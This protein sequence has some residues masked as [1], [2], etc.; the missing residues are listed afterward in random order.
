MLRCCIIKFEGSWEK[1]LPLAEFAYNNS[2]HT[3]IKMAPFEALY[4]RKCRNPL[5][6]S[7]LSE[8]KITGVDLVCEAEEK[9]KIIQGNL[10]A[11]FDR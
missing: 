1:Y 3:S 5:C 6:W 7:K 8:Q 2:Y 10:K 4:E 9:V 11:A